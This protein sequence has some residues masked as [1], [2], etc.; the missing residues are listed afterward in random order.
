MKKR[1]TLTIGIPA[2][3]EEKNIVRLL[4]DLLHN[5]QSTYRLE[6]I[7]VISDGSTDATPR[8]VNKFANENVLLVHTPKRYGQA[9]AQNLIIKRTSSD[10][11]L[12]LNADVRI[13]DADFIDATLMPFRS[14]LNVG[15]VSARVIPLPATTFIEKTINW[16]HMVKTS[17]YEKNLHSIYLCHGRA[18]IF[19]KKLYTQLAFPKII[20]EDAYSYLRA[21]ALKYRFAY[22]LD[23]RVYFRSPATLR[24]HFLQSQ[25]FIRG[26]RELALY[27]NPATLK[28]AYRLP[29]HG[30][31]TLWLAAAAAH[32]V[33]A[34]AYL[35]IHII[36]A[37]T[38]RYH[39]QH[40]Q[41]V[42]RPS[43]S[44]KSL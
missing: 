14:S 44:T 18:R 1:P 29:D 12:L 9:Y 35:S 25:R 39:E 34:A 6:K 23:A 19:S 28:S 11:L 5:R 43:E 42:W 32:P 15:L 37:I 13:K 7:I 17:M 36:S 4:T 26:K 38:L 10:Y 2:Y 33:Y 22:A 20:A 16:S 21:K 41:A 24:D 30:A 31:L 8:L 40:T 27:F 3:N